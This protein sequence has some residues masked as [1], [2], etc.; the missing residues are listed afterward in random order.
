MA[1]KKVTIQKTIDPDIRL[2]FNQWI[3]YITNLN[4]TKN[5]KRPTNT[6]IALG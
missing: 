6:N 4:K 3:R 5:G 1:K 2:T